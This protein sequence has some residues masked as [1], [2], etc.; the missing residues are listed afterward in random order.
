MLAACE[1]LRGSP[2]FGALLTAVLTL[3]NTL[4]Q[5]TMRGGAIA[6]KLDT[7]LK[8]I[9]VIE[10]AKVAFSRLCGVTLYMKHQLLTRLVLTCLHKVFLLLQ[11]I[12]LLLHCSCTLK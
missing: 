4:N 12:A 5:G 2:G 1:E 10:A 11:R 9:F 8:V 6:F 7:L 3:G